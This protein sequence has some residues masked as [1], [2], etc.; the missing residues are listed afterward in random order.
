M[1][2]YNKEE[3]LNRLENIDYY[4]WESCRDLL[5]SLPNE[6]SINEQ[7]E[8][9]LGDINFLHI[10]I[11]KSDNCIHVVDNQFEWE[12]NDYNLLSDDIFY[13][14]EEAIEKAKEISNSLN[15]PYI[16]FESRYCKFKE[17]N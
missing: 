5:E 13:D 4:L 12:I 1:G 2:I 17:M 11:V 14:L 9:M 6:K 15:I 16:S 10:I 3:L 8:E 7:Y